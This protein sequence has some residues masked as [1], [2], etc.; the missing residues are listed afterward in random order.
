ML[1]AGGEGVAR[2]VLAA[3]RSVDERI[4]RSTP[5]ASLIGYHEVIGAIGALSPAL[6]SS[7]DPNAR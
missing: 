7:G 1:T 6:E 2:S 3:M 4:C 5:D